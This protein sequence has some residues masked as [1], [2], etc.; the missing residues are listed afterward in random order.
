M[1]S[2]FREVVCPKRHNCT[3]RLREWDSDKGDDIIYGWFLR[4]R[5][6]ERPFCFRRNDRNLRD[7]LIFPNALLLLLRR[8][9]ELSSWIELLERLEDLAKDM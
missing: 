4:E 7:A 9:Q 5:A 8:T 2:R 3:D 6:R 1:M